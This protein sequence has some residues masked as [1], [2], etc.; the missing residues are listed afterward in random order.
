[1]TDDQAV[2][3]DVVLLDDLRA[4]GAT[5]SESELP[6]A[7]EVRGIVGALV[8]GLQRAGGA[9]LVEAVRAPVKPAPDL[10][11][12]EPVAPSPVAEGTAAPVVAQPTVDQTVV[13]QLQAELAE[14]RAELATRPDT[15][16]PGDTPPPVYDPDAD[17][18]VSS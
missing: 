8:K 15:P 1:M 6:S 3:D 17:R 13:A 7:E 2:A 4:E 11:A 5:L 12:G 10:I 16:E 9:D 14:A 18:E